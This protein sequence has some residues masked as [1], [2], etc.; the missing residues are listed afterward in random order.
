MLL[1]V[2]KKDAW[3]EWC[4]FFLDAVTNQAKENGIIASG[5]FKLY[6]ETLDFIMSVAR[7][8]NAARV[9]PHLFRMAIFPSNIFTRDAGLSESTSRRLIK[10]LKKDERIVEVV[11]HKGSS[12]AVF[13]FPELLRLIEGVDITNRQ[14]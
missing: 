14:P 12:P 7:S 13:A 2:S 4:I 8:D 3:T 5:I 9:T 10:A 1:L 6:E 11:P